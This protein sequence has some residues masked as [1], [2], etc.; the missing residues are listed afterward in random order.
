MA[1]VCPKGGDHPARRVYVQVPSPKTRRSTT[2]TLPFVYCGPVGTKTV[3]TPTGK[4]VVGILGGDADAPAHGLVPLDPAAFAAGQRQAHALA[5]R[6]HPAWV[7]EAP[8]P[9]PK[10]ARAKAAKTPPKGRAPKKGS[11][12]APKAKAR[13][14]ASAA[15]PA[16][17]AVPPAPSPSADHA[18]VEDR[19]AGTSTPEPAP[20][21]ASEVS[22]TA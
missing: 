19:E 18:M 12:A 20:P 4:R 7:G 13:R 11:K 22:P 1:L 6:T 21:T 16:T 9:A 3:T 14:T 2:V 5:A 8:E 15:P 10:K 17:P